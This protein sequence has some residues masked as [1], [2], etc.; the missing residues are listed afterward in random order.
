[1]SEA[2]TEAS[3]EASTATSALGARLRAAGEAYSPDEERP[4]RGYV[5]AMAAYAGLVAAVAAATRSRGLPERISP[6][7]VLLL[8]VATHRLARTISKDA[9]ASPLR[10]PFTRYRGAAAPS[11]LA[12]EVRDDGPV[13]HA[14]GELLT[15][16][17]CLAQWVA[18]GFTAG[19]LLA[20]RGTRA[21]AATLTAVAG[22]DFLQYA[23]AKAQASAH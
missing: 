21:V 16:P 6:W 7:D 20:P 1:M 2:R 9:V 15:C 4:L 22:A 5:G 13:R 23:Y 8:S 17:F 10:A 14:V 11:E 18:T 19:H 3:T 12:E